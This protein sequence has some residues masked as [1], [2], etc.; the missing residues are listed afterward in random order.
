MKLSIIIPV[1]NEARFIDTVIKKVKAVAL[2]QD[3]S[4][5]IVIV[6]D[7]STDDSMKILAN[8]KSDPIIKILKQDRNRGKTAAIKRGFENSSGDIIIIQDADLEYSPKDYPRLIGPII[9]NKAEVVYGSR[10]KG[11]IERIATINKI[12]NI[13]SNVTINLLYRTQLSDVNTCYKVFKKEILQD[14]IL[15]SNNFAFETEVTAKLLNKGY[16]IYEVP[17]RYVARTEKEGKK[18]NWPKALQ[19]YWGII[20]YKFKKGNL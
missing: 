20:Q 12:A 4:K 10:F 9:Q 15:T 13:I 16:R 3:I 18:M 2:P 1:Y 5:E 8:F 6:D 7:G 17:I 14:I 19:M 11:K